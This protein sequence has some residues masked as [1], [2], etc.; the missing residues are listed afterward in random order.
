MLT[1]DRT[2][3]CCRLGWDNWRLEF[4]WRDD[5]WAH[6]LWQDL[7][8]IRLPII[9][10]VEGT[11]EQIWPGSPAFQ[12]LHLERIN[13]DCGEIQLLGQAG[14]NHYSGAIR[15]DGARNVIDFDLAVRIQSPAAAPLTV[16]TYLHSN[17]NTKERSA[18]PTWNVIPE[19][20]SGC[21]ELSS[22][23]DAPD[24]ESNVLQ[25]LTFQ[26]LNLLKFE[27][28]RATI[29]WKYQLVLNP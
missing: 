18:Q 21:P 24:S 17:A 11:T 26:D 15:C 5:R 22:G 28:Q 27:R 13:P 16:S 3:H 29:R 8:G 19:P 14:K 12:D 10:S 9:R 20:I 4:D 23:F 1:I 6:S 7:Q 2:S 25:R